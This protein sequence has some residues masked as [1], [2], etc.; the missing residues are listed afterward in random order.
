[1]DLGLV[2]GGI[3]GVRRM[4]GNRNVNIA[5]QGKLLASNP[6]A[7]DRSINALRHEKSY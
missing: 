6:N 4:A 1:M 3:E 5:I 7:T 2:E